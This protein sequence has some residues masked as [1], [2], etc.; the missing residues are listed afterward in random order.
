MDEK[1]QRGSLY[2]EHLYV[3]EMLLMFLSKWDEHCGILMEKPGGSFGG[4][5]GQIP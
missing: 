2:I 4:N 1:A 3:F 5:G